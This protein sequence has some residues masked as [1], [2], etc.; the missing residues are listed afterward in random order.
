MFNDDYN[1]MNDFEKFIYPIF[2]NPMLLIE[3]RMEN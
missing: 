3:Y 1:K 2:L